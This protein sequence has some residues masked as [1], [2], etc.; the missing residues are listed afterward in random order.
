MYAPSINRITFKWSDRYGGS[1]T[2]PWGSWKWRITT[3]DAWHIWRVDDGDDDDGDGGE[4]EEE[5]DK[6]NTEAVA[7]MEG[8]IPII[9]R[10]VLGNSVNVLFLISESSYRFRLE[11]STVLCVFQD[12]API[13]I[14]QHTSSVSDSNISKYLFAGVFVMCSLLWSGHNPILSTPLGLHV[15]FLLGF[16]WW[17][18]LS[19]TLMHVSSWGSLFPAPFILWVAKGPTMTKT[20]A[21]YFSWRWLFSTKKPTGCEESWKGLQFERMT[22]NKQLRSLR[23]KGPVFLDVLVH[24]CFFGTN[25]LPLVASF[26]STLLMGL[27]HGAPPFV[28]GESLSYWNRLNRDRS[29]C[30]H[31]YKQSCVCCVLIVFVTVFYTYTSYITSI[32]CFSF[33]FFIF[34]HFFFQTQFLIPWTN[35]G[36]NSMIFMARKNDGQV[37]CARHIPPELENTL[38]MLRWWGFRVRVGDEG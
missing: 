24:C 28:W 10:H 8:L 29:F 5:E 2:K 26:P 34:C 6:N 25:V 1:V 3:T 20:W 9:R 27:L 14:F 38:L 13:S 16:F 11:A 22:L 18:D 21:R 12:M 31:H 33:S 32:Q 35:W 36:E 15:F 37:D 17:V 19:S 30:Y 23:G 7:S 4:E